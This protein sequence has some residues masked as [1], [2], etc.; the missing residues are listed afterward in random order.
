MHDGMN[1]MGGIQQADF[2]GADFSVSGWK[3]NRQISVGGL[4]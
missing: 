2:S 3:F 4:Q 1:S